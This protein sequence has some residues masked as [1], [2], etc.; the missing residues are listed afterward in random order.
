MEIALFGGSFDPFHVGHGMIAAYVAEFGGVDQVWVMPT[1][2][3]PLKRQQE[4]MAS[5]EQRL[6]MARLAMEE[7]FNVVISDFEASLPRPNYS[8]ETLCALRERYPRHRFHMLVGG[9]NLR[10]FK[11]WRNADRIISEFGIIVYPR[12]GVAVEEN[13]LPGIRVLK[14]APQMMMSATF[15]RR[16]MAEGHSPENFV[17]PA[18]AEYIRQNKLYGL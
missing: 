12:P 10:D 9:D 15:L 1:P 6:E 4:Y 13:N 17:A 5:Y 14:N 11:L 8:Y 16:I 3:N 18:V 2:G 7:R